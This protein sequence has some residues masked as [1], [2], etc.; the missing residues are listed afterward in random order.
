[1]DRIKRIS[2]FFRVLF[3]ISFVALPIFLITAWLKFSGTL[4]ILGGA[5][6]LNYIPAAYSNSILHTLNASER[7][8]ALCLNSIPMFIQLYILFAL[9]RLF[10]L[11]EKGEIFSINNVRYIR[12]IGYTLLITQIIDPIYNGAMGLVLTRYNPPGH[13]FAA[14]TLDETNIVIVLIALIVILI[15]WIMSEGC[16]L[17]EEQQLTV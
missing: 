6:N 14:I 1:M 9:I 16:K 11:Y 8:L 2:L 12:N 17:R 15:S 4:V 13:R 10:K 7:L 3:Q 5:I